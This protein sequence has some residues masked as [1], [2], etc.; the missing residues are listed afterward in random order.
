M[1]FVVPGEV[2]GGGADGALGGVARGVVGEGA[3]PAVVGAALGGGGLDGVGQAGLGVVVGVGGGGVGV[4]Q[5]SCAVVGLLDAVADRVVREGLPV[6]VRAA[7]SGVRGL[8]GAVGLRRPRLG[9]AA[10]S[11]VGEA[12]GVDRPGGVLAAGGGDAGDVLCVVVG[13]GD[14]VDALGGEVAVGGLAGQAAGELVVGLG[15]VELLA[16]GSVL[17][18]YGA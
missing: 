6:D 7:D 15:L 10:Q 9:Q 16:E 14:V 12:L 5:G 3:G 13:V 4:G 1:A 18:A 8:R 11:V 2:L 17:S